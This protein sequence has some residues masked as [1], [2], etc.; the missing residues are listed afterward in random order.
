MDTPPPGPARRAR[1][2]G[3]RHEA[4]HANLGTIDPRLQGFADDFIFGQVWDGDGAT[5][6]D[7]QL[8]AIVALA[9]TGRSD[10]LRNYL[11]G[12]LQA[13]IDPR[14]VHESLLMLIVYV[15]FPAAI[16]ALVVWR[17]VVWSARRRGMEVDVPIADES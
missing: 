8:V 5:P 15:G 14:R 10:Q 2:Q 3:S 9:S 12:A 16:G 4:L 13:G 17:E 1:A 6:D 11:H 7:R